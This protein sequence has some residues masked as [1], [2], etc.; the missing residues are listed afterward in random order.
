MN[1]PTCPACGQPLAA[2]APGGQCPACLLR[3]AMGDDDTPLSV[4]AQSSITGSALFPRDVFTGE[5]HSPHVLGDYELL[6]QL[7]DR[8][9]V[10]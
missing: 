7:G 3:L 1:S 5:T 9:S 8:K 10:V 2:N 6:N 4:A